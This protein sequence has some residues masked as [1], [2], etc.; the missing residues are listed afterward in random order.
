MRHRE[1]ETGSDFLT[2]A[3][4]CLVAAASDPGGYIPPG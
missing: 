1:R 3:P 2:G 4:G